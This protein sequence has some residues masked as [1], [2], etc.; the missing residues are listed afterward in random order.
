MS[1]PNQNNPN[2][3]DTKIFVGGLAWRTTTD[4]LRRSFQQFG[5]VIDA[6]VVSE[7]LQGGNLRS[8]GYGFVVFR[9]AESANRACELPW[10]VIDG[11][12]TNVNMAYLGAKN[13]NSNQPNQ[14]GLLNQAG[15]SHQYQNGLFNQAASHQH[16]LIP[17]YHNPHFPQSYW[18]P[19]YG[20]HPYMYNVPC[21]TYPTAVVSMQMQ[22]HVLAYRMQRNW[23][24]MNNVPRVIVSN[25]PNEEINE[26]NEEINEA[27]EEVNVANEEVNVANEE[28]IEANEEVNVANEEVIEANE[29]VNVANEEIIE[30]IEE[31]NV[32]NEEIIEAI[33]EA[34]EANEEITEEM[35]EYI[36]EEE[37][38]TE[39]DCDQEGEISGEGSDIKQ[40]VNDQELEI[41]IGEEDD[42]KQEVVCEEEAENAPQENGNGHEENSDQVEEGEKQEY[43][44][45]LVREAII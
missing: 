35:N 27:N 19:Y 18:A 2:F 5:E 4:E 39:T 15:P 14:N 32:A 34:I 11:R 26:A 44:K 13:N 37:A 23:E 41:M 30:A 36:N 1:Q 45:E 21:Y 31:V 38:D 22:Q 25:P 28:V 12:Q 42:T 6:N 43:N 8:K 20:Q 16:Q 3:K 29:E 40:D 33:E 9:N 17:Q 10:L 24:R 7:G